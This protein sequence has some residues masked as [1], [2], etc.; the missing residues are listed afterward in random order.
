MSG[1]NSGDTG[2]YPYGMNPAAIPAPP[3]PPTNGISAAG[4]SAAA[5]ADRTGQKALFR[6]DHRTLIPAV[7]DM[8]ASSDNG[9]GGGGGGG[10]DD[11]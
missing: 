1:Q 10:G 11:R 6:S 2:M 3:L 8:D 7:G 4:V 9:G 5:A